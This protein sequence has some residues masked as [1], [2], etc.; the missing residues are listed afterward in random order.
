MGISR[1]LEGICLD[2]TLLAKQGRVECF[3]NNIQNMDK[4]DGMVEDI[5]DAMVEYQVFL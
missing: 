3:F 2:L 1:K 4:L 5:R